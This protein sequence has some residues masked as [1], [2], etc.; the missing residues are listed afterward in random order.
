MGP[1]PRSMNLNM[2]KGTSG[3]MKQGHTVSDGM[4]EAVVRNIEAVKKLASIVSSSL[5]PN[6]HNKLVINHLEKIVVTSDAGTIVTELEIAHPAAKIVTLA[7]QQQMGEIGDGTN[8]VISFAGE[9]LKLA[10]ELLREGLVQSEVVSG[11]MAAYKLMDTLLPT[12]VCGKLEDPRDPAQLTAA[13]KPVIAAKQYGYEDFLAGLVV[14][15]ASI[16]MPAAPAAPRLVPEQIRIGKIPGAT[17]TASTCMSGFVLQ[18]TTETPLKLMEKAKITVFSSGIESA[19]TEAKGTVLIRNADDLLNYNSSEEKHLEG[20]MKSIADSGCNV[21]VSGG[22]VSEMALHFIARFGMMCLKVPSKWELRRLC[23]AVGATAL[24][25]LGPATPD[26]MGAASRVVV[27]EHAGRY[28]TLFEQDNS[29]DTKISTILIR[30]STVSMLNDIQRAVGDGAAVAKC[31]CHDPR[32]LPGAGATEMELAQRIT[33]HA[34]TCT[35]LDQYA[36]RKFGEALE[37]VARTLSENCGHDATDMVAA[38]YS[39]HAKG[40]P[41]AGVNIEGDSKDMVLVENPVVD[42]FYVKES[43]LRLAVEAAI[44]VLRVDQIIMS[45]PAGGP[46]K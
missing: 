37:C 26:E 30:A 11:Y 39:A 20:I 3:M 7:A 12:L 9:L 16:V 5:G 22:S 4:D 38:L 21:V 10:E 41:K 14:E 24:V 18:R 6:G 23:Q 35:G 15:A 25:R 32:F 44:T 45:K 17:V 43:A 40:N 31:L 2:A 36:I 33:D 1:P 34:D 29:E 8:L 13:I 46:K 42:S 27:Q 28:V 19:S